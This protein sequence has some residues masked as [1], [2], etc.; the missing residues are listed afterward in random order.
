[1][2]IFKKNTLNQ[3]VK[4]IFIALFFLPLLYGCKSDENKALDYLSSAKSYYEKDQYDLATVEI[5]NAIR[6]DATLAD[7]YVLQAKIFK[8]KRHWEPMAAFLGSALQQKPNHI[9][10]NLEMSR[11]YIQGG[12]P[13]KAQTHLNTAIESGLDSTT[14]NLLQSSIYVL[15]KNIP[16]AIDTLGT[17]LSSH[18]H[19]IEANLQLASIM[20]LNQDLHKARS[21]TLSI[22]D[23][24]PNNIDLLLL[25]AKIYTLQG[26]LELAVT[27]LK[28]VIEISPNNLNNYYLAAALLD[29]IGNSENAEIMLRSAVIENPN[30]QQAKIALA[31][32]INKTNGGDK[33]I[34]LLEDFVLQNQENNDFSINFILGDL[35]LEKENYRQAEQLY[36]DL[37]KKNVKTAATAKIKLALVELKKGQVNNALE[38]INFILSDQFNNPEALIIRSIIYLSINKPDNAIT[39]LLNALR[40][41]PNSE[42]ALFLISQAYKLTHSPEQAAIYLKQLISL[43][44]ANEKAVTLY[45][46][47]L[48]DANNTSELI[49][50]L[51]SFLEAE[52]S[53]LTIEKR[54]VNAYLRTNQWNKATYLANKISQNYSI[55]LY[56]KH[57]EA[58]IKRLKGEH[59]ESINISKYILSMNTFIPA[60]LDNIIENFSIQN[61]HHSSTLFLKS[62]IKTNPNELYAV[63]LLAQELQRSKDYISAENLLSQ[64]LIEN[65]DW[66]EGHIE[67]SRL[68]ATQENWHKSINSALKANTQNN[69]Q[70]LLLLASTYEKINNTEQAIHYYKKALTL[71]PK[72]QAIINNLALL[73]AGDGNDPTRLNEAY[74]IAR[75]F[76]DTNQPLYLDTLGWIYYLK[77]EYQQAAAL[78]EK[79]IFHAP[80]QLITHYHL[81]LTLYEIN[82]LN[83]AKL[84]LEFVR[85]NYTAESNFKYRNNALLLLQKISPLT[86]PS[87]NES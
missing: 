28:K 67:L 61:Q 36:L 80:N 50:I 57:I 86:Q 15:N 3:L 5:K 17:I 52:G 83:Q 45:S 4:K 40:E 63:Q 51:E 27:Q 79:A 2:I 68:Y 10:A 9:E 65:P 73:L 49:N 48:K 37:I 75:P 1:M 44:P 7:A 11:L 71:N 81:G 84:H 38:Q 12:L 32:Y 76:K 18:P 62:Y 87:I 60:S 8:S 30:N 77:E 58:V 23:H 6:K 31:G 42:T 56:T 26:E 14:S 19:S 22:L 16:L 25:S 74:S 72:M 78:L 41:Q 33:A 70:L 47:I 69:L 13:Q 64:Y 85:D 34:S 59:L 43:N 24:H 66:N 20:I 55:N 82:E 35:Y 53:S 54:L 46:E 21:R 39:D 29:R